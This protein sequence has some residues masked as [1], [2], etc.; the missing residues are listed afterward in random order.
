M[1]KGFA[2]A[3]I[4]KRLRLAWSLQPFP[5]PSHHGHRRALRLLPI[6]LFDAPHKMEEG[7]LHSLLN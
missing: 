6:F 5:I 2:P 4:K 3:P 7:H 1:R